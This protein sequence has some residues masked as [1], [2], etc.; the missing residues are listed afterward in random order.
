MNRFNK[1]KLALRMGVVAVPL[2]FLG[3]LISVVAVS[4]YKDRQPSRVVSSVTQNGLTAIL[5]ESTYYTPPDSSYSMPTT[6]PAPYTGT[7][8]NCQPPAG[9]TYT[10]PTDTTYPSGSTPTYTSPPSGSSTDSSTSSG[11]SGSVTSTYTM[12]T[13]CP[14]GYSGTPPNCQPA[15][16][17]SQSSDGSTGTNTSPNTSG[18]EQYQGSTGSSSQASGSQYVAPPPTFTKSDSGS[19]MERLLGAEAYA[20]FQAGGF[21]ATGD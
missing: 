15:A 13:T 10:A 18:A 7:P 16:G 5:G 17:T 4:V 6:C 2:A 11:S 9:S 19:C 3:F 21:Q 1:T 12:P 8:P 14:S 20:R